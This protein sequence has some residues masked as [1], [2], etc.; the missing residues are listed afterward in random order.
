MAA[1]TQGARVPIYAAFL[2]AYVAFQLLVP[3]RHYVI[4]GNVH[5]T[6]EGH[7]F[8]WHM[9]LR[10]KEALSA[11]YVATGDGTRYLVNPF[12]HLTSEQLSS[13]PTRPDMIWQYAR[14]LE[15]EAK[16][17]GMTEVSVY[18]D[19]KVSLNGRDFQPFVDRNEALNRAPRPKPLWGHINWV[20]P[21][22]N[23]GG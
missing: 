15:T 9:K 19:V 11:I 17:R 2:V 3:L 10:D 6:E 13:F 14:F 22:G 20:W 16:K 4:P 21:L 8:S 23:G 18:A 7:D 1:V 5:R 12:E